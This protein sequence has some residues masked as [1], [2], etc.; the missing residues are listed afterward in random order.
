MPATARLCAAMPLAELPAERVFGEIEKLLLQARRPSI[1]LR[2]LREWG[3]LAA[4]GAR[5]DAAR[6]HAAGPRMASRG[7]RVDAHAAGGRPGRAA[8]RTAST[9]RARSR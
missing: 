5:A 2:L 9:G 1:G 8:G 4:R 6:R 7:R 3:M